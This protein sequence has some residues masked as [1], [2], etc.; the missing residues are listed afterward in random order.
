MIRDHSTIDEKRHFED[1]V[2]L[3]SSAPADSLKNAESHREETD[4]TCKPESDEKPETPY[5][6]APFA[7]R[8]SQISDQCRV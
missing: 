5:I 4:S 7:L 2:G 6:F 3:R 1:A 8:P